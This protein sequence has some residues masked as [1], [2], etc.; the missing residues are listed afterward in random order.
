MTQITPEHRRTEKC[1]VSYRNYNRGVEQ[2]DDELFDDKIA[3]YII[4]AIRIK[5]QWRENVSRSRD[6]VLLKID[7]F[8][9]PTV[10]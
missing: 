1:S 3:K 7:M 8:Y 4:E 6:F 2:S 5:P 10:R 9:I